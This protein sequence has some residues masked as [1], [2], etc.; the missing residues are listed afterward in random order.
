MSVFE[1]LQQDGASPARRGRL[2]TRRGDIETPAFM[3]VGTR[4]TVKAM[5]VEGLEEVGA[6]IILA[7]TYHLLL[8]PGHEL[9][10]RRGGLHRFM[11]WD[12]PILT[13]SGGFQVFSLG[14][15]RRIS[16]EGV[17]FQSHIDGASHFLSPEVAM[18]V[19]ETLGAD[20]LMAFDE[21]I[22]YPATRDYAATATARS[23]RWAR[24]SKAARTPGDDAALFGI[25]QGGMYEDLRRRSTEELLD[26]GFDGYALGGLSVGESA[27]VMYQVMDW[28]LPLLPAGQPRYVM[29]V[30]TPENLVEAVSRGADM[31]DCVMPTRNARNGL[32]FTTFGK[33]SIKQ[34]RYAED[35]GPLDPACSC[36]VCRNYSR[37]YLRH[38][39][40][41]G[42]ILSSMLNTH[43]NL[44]YYLTL[45]Q[46]MRT[47]LEE[48][49]FKVF[50]DDFYR[51][52]QASATAAV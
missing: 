22:P 5:S 34:A 7:N 1:L 23:G 2:R 38:L 46:G 12:R 9:V 25:V 18:Q 13:D 15:L 37:A 44:H 51:R 28:T 52:R 3:P 20:I 4:G 29:G 31:F 21:C 30:G 19:Q 33:V 43:H 50:K 36:R 6:Q 11:H 27:E 35:D 39:Y 41:S 14:E 48:G 17:R 10:G 40:Q 16:E 45:M 24:R 42:E 8:R 32:L 26:I 47:A 49:S